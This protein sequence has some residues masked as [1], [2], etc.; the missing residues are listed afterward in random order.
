PHGFRVLVVQH[1][2]MR[3]APGSYEL[4][5]DERLRLSAVVTADGDCQGEHA[6]C[7]SKQQ[8]SFSLLHAFPSDPPP[9]LS[10]QVWSGGQLL[11][12]QVVEP[13][14]HFN[15]C[16]GPGCGRFYTTSVTLIVDQP[17]E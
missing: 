8:L 6:M 11:G 10:M 2:L 9:K 17:S 7:Y 16:N 4:V 15:E 1:E 14:Y 5:V 3:T 12:S 13:E